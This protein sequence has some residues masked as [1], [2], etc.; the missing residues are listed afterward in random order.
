MKNILTILVTTSAL[1]LTTASFAAQ[2]C[3]YELDKNSVQVNWTAFKTMQKVAVAGSFPETKISGKTEKKSTFAKFLAQISAKTDIGSVNDIH[4][5]NPAR[6]TTLLDHFFKKFKKDSIQAS[7]Q[8]V[9]GSDSE[10]EFAMKLVMN[11]KTLSVPMKFTRDSAGKF[12]AKG[13]IDVLAFALDQAF[14][15]LHQT[16]EA[17]H[18]GPDGVS[19]TWPNVEIKLNATITQTKCSS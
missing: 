16:C 13:E 11:E 15:E 18:K 14:A 3:Q 10:G 5:G 4:T 2:N 17:L 12:E 7:I 1:F 6:D 8:N 19:K 9:K